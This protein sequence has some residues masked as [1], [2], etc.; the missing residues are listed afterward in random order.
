MDPTATDDVCFNVEAFCSLMAET[1]LEAES[2]AEFVDLAVDFAND[3]VWGSLSATVLAHPS[4]LK[5]PELGPR[6]QAA[7]ENLRYGGIGLNLWH[8]L[9]FAFSTTTWGAYPGHPRNDIQSGSG[10][11]GNAY[12]LT[13]TQKSVIRGPFRAKPKPAWFVTA[14]NGRA[15]MERLLSFEAAPS[16]GRLASLLLAALRN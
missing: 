7:I 11:V 5:D 8:G 13:H 9:V 1:A 2:P 15:T 16:I 3:V 6:I 14:K 12:M 10:V 4:S